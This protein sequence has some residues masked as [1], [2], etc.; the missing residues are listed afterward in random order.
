MLDQ[1]ITEKQRC[2]D[3][4]KGS[5]VSTITYLFEFLDDFQETP[6]T[7]FYH[8]ILNVFFKPPTAIQASFE[9]TDDPKQ[10]DESMSWGPTTYSKQ[11]HPLM[12]MVSHPLC[13]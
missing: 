5:S 13:R 8:R 3:D 2:E 6:H 12:L 1:C 9:Y 7:H 11:L 10:L 4:A